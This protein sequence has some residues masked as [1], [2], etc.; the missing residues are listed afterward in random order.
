MN[1]L[2]WTENYWVGGCDRFVVDLAAG[3]EG[4]PVQIALAGNEHPEFD[5][6]L[7]SRAPQLLPRDTLPVA[8]LVRSPLQRL[9]RWSRAGQRR[10]AQPANPAL[11][12]TAAP[13]GPL[14]RQAG[15]ATLRYSQAALN[16]R[17]LRSLLDRRRPDVLLINNGGY[18]GAESC[19]MAA[20]A[21]RAA[22]VPRVLH[23]V[24]NMAHPPAWPA[25]IERRLDRRID[26]ATD[27]WITAAER[28]SDALA[29][30][31]EIPQTRI[32][33]VHYGLPDSDLTP[34]T[35][36]PELRAELGFDGQALG[37][38]AVANMEPRKGLGVLLDALAKLR[39]QGVRASVALVGDGP[40]RD[41][42]GGRADELGL[43]ADVRFLG[44]R[45]DVGSILAASDVLVLPSLANECLPYVILEAM[46]QGLPVVS[47]DVA[48]I[49]EMV[50]DGTTGRVLAPGDAVEL[51]VALQAL[52][53]EPDVRRQYGQRGRARVLEHFTVGRMVERMAQLMGL[54]PARDA[55]ALP[56]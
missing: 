35:A 36:S 12:D 37:I 17:R 5:A 46:A 31:R 7:S 14:A 2:I 4:Q 54:T 55:A 27:V 26:A 39:H 28:A 20:L 15:V 34:Q 19:R 25:A 45:D 3:L 1:L 21:A 48:G 8:N 44:W 22:G 11:A 42:L 38:V 50:L 40:E 33:T 16:L 47:T 30:R 13:S 6:W 56:A 23:F 9:D 29:Q 41:A 24:H 32:R 10:P 43:R 52:A 51:S 18:P 49:P 53:A